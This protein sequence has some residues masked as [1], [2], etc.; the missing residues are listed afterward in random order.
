MFLSRS[1]ISLGLPALPGR[2]LPLPAVLQFCILMTLAYESAVGLF[3]PDAEGANVFFV[4]ILVCVE[5]IC[6]GLA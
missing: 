4:F 5:G 1:S 3:P 6:G 2:L